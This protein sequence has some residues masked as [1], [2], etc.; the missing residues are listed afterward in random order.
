MPEF[1]PRI[2]TIAFD[3]DCLSTTGSSVITFSSLDARMWSAADM[4]DGRGCAGLWRRRLRLSRRCPHHLQSA[5]QVTCVEATR[6]RECAL[7]RRIHVLRK[8]T[9]SPAGFLPQAG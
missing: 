8:S 1:L 2:T 3:I 7:V 9:F 6:P 5:D 4:I